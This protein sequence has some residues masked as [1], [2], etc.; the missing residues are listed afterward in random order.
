MAVTKQCKHGVA[1]ERCRCPEGHGPAKIGPC[2]P[3]CQHGVV[4]GPIENIA[5]AVL[6]SDIASYELKAQAQ[7]ILDKSSERE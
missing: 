7:A 4:H 3:E 6:E 1:I 2:P 5:K